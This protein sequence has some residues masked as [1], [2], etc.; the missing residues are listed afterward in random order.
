MKAMKALSTTIT[1]FT[2][3]LTLAS[4]FLLGTMTASAG[5]A[6][7]MVTGSAHTIDED[8]VFRTL[9]CSMVAHADGSVSGQVQLVNHDSGVSLHIELLCALRVDDQTLIV[10]GQVTSANSPF[11]GYS[12][13][14]AL[15]DEGRGFGA[16]DEAS[17]MLSWGP[18]TAEDVIEECEYNEYLRDVEPEHYQETID[19]FLEFLNPSV[20]GNLT[21]R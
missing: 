10:F 11:K 14:F 20:A 4:A 21:I 5:G 16:L 1:K 6:T 15:R 8:G 13:L 9:G 18:A 19:Y 2:A 17:P 12:A 3:S 7:P